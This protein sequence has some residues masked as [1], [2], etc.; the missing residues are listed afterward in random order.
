[1]QAREIV[2]LMTGAA[3]DGIYSLSVSAANL[4]CVAMAVVT[5]T[6]K[7]TTGVAIHTA[8][9]A[10]HWNNCFESRSGAGIVA[11]HDFMDDLCVGMFHSLNGNPYNQQR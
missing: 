9:V 4:H 11:R 3:S 10:K 5:L 6:R 2:I 7:V 8:R 1:V